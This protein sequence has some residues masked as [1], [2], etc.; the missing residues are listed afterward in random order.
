VTHDEM[1]MKPGDQWVIGDRLVRKLVYPV[2]VTMTGPDGERVEQID[3]LRLRMRIKGKDM[4]TMD[5]HSGDIAKSI[6]MVARLSGQ[7]FAVID[8]LDSEDLMRL[9]DTAQGFTTPGLP[10]GPSS[11][12]S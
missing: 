7:S 12:A 8:E 1:A 9:I 4:R 2:D 11:S 5:N 6:A 10:T 3:T